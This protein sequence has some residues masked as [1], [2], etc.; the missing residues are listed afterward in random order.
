[1]ANNNE[2]KKRKYWPLHPRRN[3]KQE[4]TRIHIIDQKWINCNKAYELK[5]KKRIEKLNEICMI[6]KEKKNEGLE[7]KRE[8]SCI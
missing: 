3:E 6:M 8:D 7:V 2:E 5:A 4:R 1:M